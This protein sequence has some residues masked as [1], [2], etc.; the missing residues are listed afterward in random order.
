MQY[1]ASFD[2]P[3]LPP[4]S[5]AVEQRIRRRIHPLILLQLIHLTLQTFQQPIRRIYTSTFTFP[6]HGSYHLPAASHPA[7]K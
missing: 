4:L 2:F 6:Q 5:F 7:C 3:S 1:N